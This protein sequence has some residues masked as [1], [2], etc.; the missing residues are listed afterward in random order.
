MLDISNNFYCQCN[1]LDGTVF[2]ICAFL[3][4]CTNQDK[5][6]NGQDYPCP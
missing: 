2:K 4:L 5:T 6:I 1:Y 3:S